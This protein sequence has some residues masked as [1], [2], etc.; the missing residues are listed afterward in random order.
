MGIRA[1]CPLQEILDA[2][3]HQDG[4]RPRD[5]ALFRAGEEREIMSDEERDPVDRDINGLH[6]KVTSHVCPEQY[7]V[8]NGRGMPV[9]YVRL[10]H[11]Q[12]RVDYP[13]CLEE[14][15]IH[16]DLE[17]D[18]GCFVSEERRAYWLGKAAEAIR[19]R[20]KEGKR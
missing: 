5:R 15:L 1:L 11:G 19:A 7:D 12:F 9:G 6:F 4:H 17:H 2:S 10:R 13:R 8:F 18:D 16:E 14:T 20:M 3:Q